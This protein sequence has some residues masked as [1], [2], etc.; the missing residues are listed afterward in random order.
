MDAYGHLEFLLQNSKSVAY[1]QTLPAETYL[2]LTN[3]GQETIS[4]P[5]KILI[6]PSPHIQCLSTYLRAVAL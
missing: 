3:S 4:G 5:W 6:H 1:L 2:L